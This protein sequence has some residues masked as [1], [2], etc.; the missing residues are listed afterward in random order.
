MVLSFL[1]L[2]FVRVVQLVRL[3]CRAQDDLA[4]EI[5]IL[6]HDHQSRPRSHSTNRCPCRADP[7]VP[8]CCLNW[9]DGVLDTHR[10]PVVSEI[11]VGSP[12]A[13]MVKT[14]QLGDG[15]MM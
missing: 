1:Y 2:A 13:G 3:S 14:Q 4:I 10:V 8:A 5:V 7:R 9:G 6:R 11:D 15:W 12:T